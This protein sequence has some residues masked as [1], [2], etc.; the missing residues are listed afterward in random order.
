MD[1]TNAFAENIS[2]LLHNIITITVNFVLTKFNPLISGKDN[3]NN[4][5]LLN[6]IFYAKPIATNV[7]L[8]VRE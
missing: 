8:I 7:H 6:I 5:T 1:T 3:K 4:N 2:Q